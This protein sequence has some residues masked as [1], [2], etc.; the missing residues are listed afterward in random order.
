[1]SIKNKLLMLLSIIS[2]GLLSIESKVFYDEY[3]VHSQSTQADTANS[4]IDDLINVANHLA[5]ERGI[6]NAALNNPNQ[7]DTGT[8][9]KITALRKLSDNAFKSAKKNALKSGLTIETAYVDALKNSKNAL[10]TIRIDINQALTLNKNARNP[11]IISKWFPTVTAYIIDT[12]KLRINLG[13]QATSLSSNI[14]KDSMLRHSVWLMSEY[15]GRERGMLAGIIASN[16]SISGTQLQQ[17]LTY[18]G[19]VEEG[20]N[21]LENIYLNNA[22]HAEYDAALTDMKKQFF[23]NFDTIRQAIYADSNDNTGYQIT[24]QKWIEESTKAINT[25]TKIKEINTKVTSKILSDTK[26]N[27]L[28]RMVFFGL[29]LIFSVI[30]IGVVVRVINRDVIDSILNLSG[31]MKNLAN[32]DLSQEIPYTQKTDEI[33][34]MGKALLIFKDNALAQKT[35]E[36]AKEKTAKS[37]IHLSHCMKNLADGDLSQEVPYSD[38]TDEVGD[39]AKAMLIFKHVALTQKSLEEAKEQVRQAIIHLSQSMQKLA[40]GDLSQEV[41]YSTQKDEVGDMAKAML[42]FKE[43][44]IERKRLE[45]IK[46]AEIAESF[47]RSQEL[48]K[49]A[50]A[51]SVMAKQGAVGTEQLNDSSKETIQH[52]QSVA[53]ATEELSSSFNDT[54]KQVQIATRM[55]GDVVEKTVIADK[56]AVV[57]G[58]ASDRVKSVLE[59]IGSI[60]KQINLLAL[61]AKIESARAG[62]AG[63]GFSVVAGEVKNLAQRTDESVSEIQAMIHD[64]NVAT[65]NIVNSLVDIKTAT[66]KVDETSMTISSAV[67]EQTATTQE[68][69]SNMELVAT[70]ARLMS[71]TISELATSSQHA[72]QASEQVNSFAQDM[73]NGN[74]RQ[75]QSSNQASKKSVRRA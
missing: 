16:T 60:A 72:K 59:M 64:M 32:G 42:I 57:L 51:L 73:T 54:A 46:E 18:R 20:W 75:G 13:S 24:A 12:Q 38:Y 43:N 26:G 35:L 39:M 70:Q 2:L 1:M 36:A 45:E 48:A 10:D 31:V 58:T 15:A 27:A 47:K 67:E 4:A 9:Q 17:L 11:N 33:G 37:I 55:I 65:Q 69:S 29:L 66:Y 14:G 21:I 61:N 62:D 74:A 68:I 40:H 22:E 44:A 49:I 56:Y 19:K 34:G 63:K 50:S 28:Y 23:G 71:Q 5:A 3:T 25:I 52:I 53:K 8:L 7:A 30:M 41:P 6:T